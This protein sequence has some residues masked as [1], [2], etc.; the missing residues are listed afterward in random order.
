MMNQVLE[1]VSGMMPDVLGDALPDVTGPSIPK[2]K[3]PKI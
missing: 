3:Q 2:F 1:G